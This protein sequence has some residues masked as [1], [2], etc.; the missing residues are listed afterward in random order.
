MPENLR[1]HKGEE[2]SLRAGI[3]SAY[4]QDGMAGEH[5]IEEGDM[6]TLVTMQDFLAAE[7]GLTPQE[8][9]ERHAAALGLQPPSEVKVKP[10]AS[11]W[12]FLDE[13]L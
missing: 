4:S 2:S 10:T 8:F 6:Q 12:R 13:C 1:L 5:D 9:V 3:F 11:V 7:G